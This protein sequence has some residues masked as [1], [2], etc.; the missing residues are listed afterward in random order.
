MGRLYLIPTPLGNVGDLAPRSRELLGSLDALLCE[1][2]RTT[3]RLLA[4]LD[5]PVPSLLP[6]HDHNERSQVGRVLQRLERSDLGLVSEAGTP[7]LS[8]PGYAVVR[9]VIAAGHEVVSIPGPSAAVTALVGSGLPADR[10]VFVGFPPR[11]SSRRQ[12]WLAPLSRRGETVILYEAPRR[13]LGCLADVASTFGPDRP[14]ALAVNLSKKGERFLRGTVAS[15]AEALG[16]EGEVR[17]EMTLIL[18]GAP[19]GELA[20][21]WERAEVLLGMLRGSGLPA[22]QIRD[23]ICAALDLP[24]R[25]VYQRILAALEER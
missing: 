25:E 11:S 19:D 7:L 21:R 5:L 13:I 12:T 3:A 15:I 16:K 1:D 6:L 22:G 9:A 17:G 20:A 14:A 2:T 8:D 23:L 10:F 24:R 18:A 4:R